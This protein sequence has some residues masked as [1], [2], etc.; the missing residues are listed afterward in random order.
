MHSLI[1]RLAFDRFALPVERDGT[2]GEPQCGQKTG[3]RKDPNFR[4]R[5]RSAAWPDR[6]GRQRVRVGPYKK[7]AGP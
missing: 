1:C 7:A 3:L 4:C 2:P 5:F 6:S